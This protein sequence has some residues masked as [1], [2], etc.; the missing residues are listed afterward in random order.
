MKKQSL[1]KNY[2]YNLVF[3]LL[4]V[5]VPLFTV[6]YVT[7]IILP[8]QIGVFST[9]QSMF[10]IITIAAQFGVL[11]Y[12]TRAIAMVHDDK[13]QM[14]DRFRRIFSTQ[15]LTTLLFLVPALVLS[16]VFAGAEETGWIYAISACLIL[17][18]TV[19]ISWFYN[20]LEEFR[21]TVTRNIFVKIVA[22]AL[23][24]ILVKTKE[25]IIIYTL[26]YIAAAFLG[27]LTMFAGLKRFAGTFKIF[28][29]KWIDK[30]VLKEAVPYMVPMLL[31]MVF[32]EVSRY[33]VYG[34]S[35]EAVTGI[36]DQALKIVRMMIIITS[37][38]VAV[39]TPRMSKLVASR[40]YDTMRDYFVKIFVI[41]A[42]QSVLVA[43]G[44]IVVGND[45]VS[46]F[47]GEKFAGV[48]PV[49]SVFA[50]YPILFMI[51]QCLLVLLLRPLGKTKAMLIAIIV[52]LG[53]NVALNAVLV[54]SLGAIGGALSLMIATMVD[55]LVQI[56]W[57]HTYVRWRPVIKNLLIVLLS[58]ALT[59]ALM[60]F[61]KSRFSLSPL[62]GFFVYGIGCVVVYCAIVMLVGKDIR[63]YTL[64]YLKRF[65]GRFK[66]GDAA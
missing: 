62:P 35:G 48:A 41:L 12:G 55:V 46:F 18:A 5:I 9:A 63:G 16:F 8:E 29:L 3:N 51:D 28:S 39:A 66:R 53:V 32:V 19:D 43:A 58:G 57:C 33:F 64:M 13:A 56:F 26:I 4:N 60:L 10:T 11:V 25:D 52:S 54:P 24:F 30:T 22:V 40:S 7:R 34:I 38:L 14:L 50:F 59:T 36:Y 31:T 42:F 2:I 20:G 47:F 6:P 23:I 21:I 44:V 37:A 49:L 17:N 65:F 61:A 15:V 45:F 1:A 27:N